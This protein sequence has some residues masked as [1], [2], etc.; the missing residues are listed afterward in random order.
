M[1]SWLLQLGISF[2]HPWVSGSLLILAARIA[3]VYICSARA[4]VCSLIQSVYTRY[5]PDGITYVV[6]LG[7][8]SQYEGVMLYVLVFV[9][10]ICVF[11]AYQGHC[12]FDPGP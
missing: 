3:M 2:D 8:S 7:Y 6:H 5:R 1:T 4:F 9:V 10:C 11:P 12:R